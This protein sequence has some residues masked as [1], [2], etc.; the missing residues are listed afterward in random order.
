MSEADGASQPNDDLH[1][2]N[3]ENQNEQDIQLTLPLFWDHLNEQ[4][5]EAYST[6]RMGLSSPACKHRRHHSIDLN[7]EIIQTIK[8]FVIRNDQDDWKRALVSGIA[9]FPQAIAINTRQLRLLISKCKSSI[10]A[11]FQH[12]GYVTIPTTNEYSNLL[13]SYMPILKD[14]FQEQRKWTIR[15]QGNA[16][17]PIQTIHQLQINVL[18]RNPNQSQNGDQPIIQPTQAEEDNTQS[19]SKLA[20][21][22]NSK[23]DQDANR[24]SDSIDDSTKI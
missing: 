15:L 14:N 10:N 11:L 9:W 24:K 21:S 7:R 16:Q 23:Y 8:K 1:L 17:F 20:N 4:D 2:L 3:Q 6:M 22:E 18:S 5:K 19:E 12:L 13:V